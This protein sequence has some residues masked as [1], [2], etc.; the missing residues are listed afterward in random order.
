[1]RPATP[2]LRRHKR[3]GATPAADS[4][5]LLRWLFGG[6]R[7]VGCDLPPVGVLAEEEREATG[8]GLVGQLQDVPPADDRRLRPD[9]LDLQI[10]ECQVAALREL[11]VLVRGEV[12]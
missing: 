11:P 8:G 1:M 9:A 12:L 5:F 7:V 6:G 4:L 3:S 10:F 2:A